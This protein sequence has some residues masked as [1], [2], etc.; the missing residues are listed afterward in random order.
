MAGSGMQQVRL[1]VQM[2]GGFS[3][4]V[5]GK[6]LSDKTE[7]SRQLISLLAFLLIKR[8]DYT[9]QER[10]MEVLWPD[11]TSENP[12]NALKNLIYRLRR[13]LSGNE[14]LRD[15]DCIVLSGG[16]YAW[17]RELA[18]SIDAEEMDR[19]Y[20]AAQESRITVSNRIQLYL[21]AVSLYRG[22]FL[23]DLCHEEWVTPLAT[24]Y[25]NIY[26]NCIYEVV[27]LLSNKGD[28]Q[29]IVRICE[30]AAALE[31]YE[32]SLHEILL[33]AYIKLG[34]NKRAQEYYESISKRFYSDLGVRLSPALQEIHREL[35]GSLNLVETDL[36]L[37]KEELLEINQ[38]RGAF[39]CDYG[40]FK[41]LYRLEIRAAERSGQP[42]FICLMT[43]E[44]VHRSAPQREILLKA[45]ESLKAILLSSLRKGDVVTRFSATQFIMMLPATTFKNGE[46]VLERIRSRF[47]KAKRNPD[48]LLKATLEPVFTAV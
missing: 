28:Y 21:Q 26:L 31:P 14:L 17:N 46:L 5:C 6:S 44:H 39:L 36:G 4:S 22:R 18:C 23:T 48:I 7:R 16:T 47:N 12:A 42:F 9:S 27:K 41:H 8:F 3:L 45:A 33:R 32:E 35:V 15:V 24:Y 2:L 10:L 38:E 11:E 13:L 30:Q 20:R 1:D 29:E 34:K 37:I 25:Q 19:L 40:I 43:L